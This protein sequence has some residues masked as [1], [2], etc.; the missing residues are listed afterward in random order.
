MKVLSQS[1]PKWASKTIGD[2]NFT[3]GRLGCTIS[4]LSMLS[5][6]YGCYLPPDVLAKELVFTDEA[7]VYWQPIKD[8]L[9]YE[10]TYRFYGK[11]YKRI[12]EALLGG[13][14]TTV[15][16]EVN[17]SHWVWCIGKVGTGVYRIADPI[18][19]KIRTT[20]RYGNNIT[21]G[22]TFKG[23]V[24]VKEQPND[25][26]KDAWKEMVGMGILSDE[27]PHAPMTREEV[28]IALKRL[29]EFL[30]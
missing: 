9:C 13:E 27:R 24:Q 7:R 6:Y 26:A 5:D 8:H 29:K 3:I 19:G 23:K 21:G 17:K 22:A 11:D 10:F 4:C 15:I 25:F 1:D 20:E 30:T 12:D 16:L 14:E 2:T 28:A 18:D